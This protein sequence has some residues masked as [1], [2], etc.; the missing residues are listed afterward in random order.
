M[1][2]NMFGF[3]SCYLNCFIVFGLQQSSIPPSILGGWQCIQAIFP[4]C[5]VGIIHCF[6]N[7]HNMLRG[8]RSHRP[9]IPRW[10]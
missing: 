7:L 4:H 8:F 10:F 2:V 6:M 3:S 5:Q 1:Y 9:C